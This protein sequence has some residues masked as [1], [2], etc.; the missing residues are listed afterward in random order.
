MPP[1]FAALLSVLRYPDGETGRVLGIDPGEMRVGVAV[2]DEGRLLA[3]PL[4]TLTGLDDRGVAAAIALVGTLATVGVAIAAEVVDE[5]PIVVQICTAVAIQ[6]YTYMYDSGEIS[7]EEF[8]NLRAD[9]IT[10]F[11]RSVSAT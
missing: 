1:D 3:R 11:L 8:E 10:A 5:E 7:H 4:D 6:D 9:A 2:S